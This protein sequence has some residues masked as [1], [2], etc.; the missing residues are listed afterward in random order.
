MLLKGPREVV[1]WQS[2]DHMLAAIV[3]RAQRRGFR[4]TRDPR[5]LVAYVNEGRWLVD[6]PRC[7]NGIPVSPDWSIA[8]CRACGRVY[9][10]VVFP[11]E[12]HIIE[13]LLHE[14]DFEHQ[15]W[16]PGESVKALRDENELMAVPV[17][18]GE[19]AQP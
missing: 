7:N 11:S 3:A 15:Q 18:L 6:C 9:S 13:A 5:Q 10:A 17:R 8:G 2:E 16:K 1:G 19:V 14:R 4:V 12:F